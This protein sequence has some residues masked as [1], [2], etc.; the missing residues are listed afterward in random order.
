MTFIRSIAF[1]ILLAFLAGCAGSP[2]PLPS[3]SNAYAVVK[4]PSLDGS[5]PSYLIGPFDE[6]QISVF[7]E[8]DLSFD[9]IQVDASGSF[10]YP[11]IGVVH[12]GGKSAE[13]VSNQIRDA[14]A[15]SYLVNPQVSVLVTAS[16]S[17]R[18][19]VEGSV[20]EPGVYPI[21][22]TTTLLSALASS[23]S[24]TK[25]AKLDQIVVFR[26]IDGQRMGAVFNLKDIRTGRA[27]DPQILGGDVI[28]VGFDSVKG[29][30][31]DFLQVA[32]LAALINSFRAF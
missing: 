17:Q 20:N 9:K 24:P 5:Q 4:P 3:G 18:Y 13:E 31:R 21:Q 15:K 23:K 26:T 16:V 1:L 6:L 2:P 11:L 28:V 30:F 19:T 14:L 7:Q 29:A 27:P 22:G 10:A 8:P 32:P 25:V 12:A